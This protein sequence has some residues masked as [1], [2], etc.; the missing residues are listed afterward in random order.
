MVQY[1]LLLLKFSLFYFNL[2]ISLIFFPIVFF[3]FVIFHIVNIIFFSF[4]ILLFLFL[5]IFLRSIAVISF[6]LTLIYDV[7]QM[8]MI[9]TYIIFYNLFH[10]YNKIKIYIY[11]LCDDILI[12]FTLVFYI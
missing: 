12:L 9:C 5:L 7:M 6:D 8:I 4:F 10:K 2:L 1:Y 3:S 11:R